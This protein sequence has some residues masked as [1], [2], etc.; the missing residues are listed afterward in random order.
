M[1]LPNTHLRRGLLVDD[2]ILYAHALQ[3]ALRRRGLDLTI[4]RSVESAKHS[5]ANGHLDFALIDLRPGNES[6]L[7]LIESLRRSNPAMRIVLM[8]AYASIA[9]TAEAI[10]RGADDYLPKPTT[11]DIIVRTLRNQDG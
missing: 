2:D 3:R 8:S 5:A 9:T 7:A 6:G 11:A 10:R 4:A 1:S